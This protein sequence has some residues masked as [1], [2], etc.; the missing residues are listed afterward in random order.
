MPDRIN[1]RYRSQECTL[2]ILLNLDIRCPISWKWKSLQLKLQCDFCYSTKIGHKSNKKRTTMWI[3]R[4]YLYV[5]K[6]GLQGLFCELFVHRYSVAKEA[7]AENMVWFCQM[8]KWE[9]YIRNLQ[10]KSLF[11][12]NYTSHNGKVVLLDRRH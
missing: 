9:P 10:R 8:L 3:T 7:T 4:G 5:L 1:T 12:K 6:Y 11:T 2:T